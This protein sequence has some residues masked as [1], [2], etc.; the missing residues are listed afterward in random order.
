M[1]TICW[2]P[3]T[4]FWSARRAEHAFVGGYE[5]I[6]FDLPATAHDPAEIGFELFGPPDYG[7]LI[8]TGRAETFDLARA[9]AE[10]ALGQETKEAR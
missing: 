3:D 1:I 5:L 10:V 8:A 6:A 7:T 9:A 4:E 2:I